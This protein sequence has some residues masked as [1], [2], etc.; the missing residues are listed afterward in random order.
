MKATVWILSRLKRAVLRANIS[1]V[2]SAIV[3]AGLLAVVSRIAANRGSATELW[4]VLQQTWVL[5]LVLTLPYLAARALVWQE[6]LRD[7]RIRVPLKHMAISFAGGE[8]TKTLPAGIY[9]QNYLLAR[10]DNLG[11]GSTVRSSMATTAMLGLE[12]ALALP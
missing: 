2:I 11:S 1:V 4:N 5:V 10:L 7:L 3:A 8:I 9:V 6:L 12:T